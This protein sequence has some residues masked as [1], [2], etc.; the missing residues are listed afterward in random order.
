M[1]TETSERSKLASCSQ[2]HHT[3]LHPV[4][5]GQIFLLLQVFLVGT[6]AREV[7][8][9]CRNLLRLPH[10]SHQATCP[11]WSCPPPSTTTTRSPVATLSPMPMRSAGN[12]GEPA[13]GPPWGAGASAGA[14]GAGL[15]P[16][17]A[18]SVLSQLATVPR[19]WAPAAGGHLQ[20]AVGCR[21]H[22]CAQVS[23]QRLIGAHADK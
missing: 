18:R 4:L 15:T 17:W 2:Q 6:W 11:R 5:Q 7:L 9:G 3:L 22:L 19:R 21:S 16:T 12:T 23:G 10:V 1:G 13:T 14:G 8:A 20:A